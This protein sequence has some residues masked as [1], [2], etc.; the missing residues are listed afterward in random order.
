MAQRAG[1]VS[2]QRPRLWPGW[3]AWS[4][5]VLLLVLGSAYAAGPLAQE[6]GWV[7]DGG[8]PSV[9]PEVITELHPDPESLGAGVVDPARSPQ[10]ED[11]DAA[12][13]AQQVAAT[14]PELPG[15]YAGA[16]ADLDGGALDYDMAA[17]QPMIPASTL[18]IMV[19]VALLDQYGPDHSFTTRVVLGTDGQLV[20]VGGGDPLLASTPTS[21]PYAS[22]ITL[23]TSE[24]LARRTAEALGAQGITSIALGYDDQLFSGDSWH[25]R[26]PAEHRLYVA[27]VTALAIDEGATSQGLDSPSDGAAKVFADQLRAF[28][29]DVTGTPAPASGAGGSELAAVHSAPLGLIV[30]ELLVHS[31]NYVSEVLLRQLALGHGQPGSF[32]GGAAALTEHLAALGLW[33]DGQ[34]I[35]DGSGLSVDNR[36]TTGALVAALQLAAERDDL[37]WVLGGMP[38][39]CATGTLTNRFTDEQSLP[40]RGQVRAKTGTLNQVSALAGYTP[41][42]DGGLLAFA[43]IGN[44][45]PTDQDVRGWFD[46]VGAALAGCDCVA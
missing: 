24:N 42:S 40:A 35:S 21:Y 11:A 38:V 28:G 39:G 2:G 4:L 34:Q 13:V 45:L 36:L 44:D 8:Q 17:N 19:A 1:A 10:V 25:P 33:R 9:D 18:K 31:D 26:W 32:E 30:Q 3:L 29:I 22:T 7:V 23:P 20:L 16:V 6:R 46:H 27:P 37:G 43:F 5:A 14:P 41:T 12:Q 15:S